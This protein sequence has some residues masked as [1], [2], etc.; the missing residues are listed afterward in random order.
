[1]SCGS[2]LGRKEGKENIGEG[3]EDL[4]ITQKEGRSSLVAQWVKDP[5]LSLQ[6]LRSLLWRGFNPWPGNFHMLRVQPRK[7]RI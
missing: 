5:V 6:W 1:M 2:V 7:K 4:V 3:E